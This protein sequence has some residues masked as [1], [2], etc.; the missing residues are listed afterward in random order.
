M[1]KV[2]VVIPSLHGDISHLALMC[3]SAVSAG[4][5]PVVIANSEDL[6]KKLA[7]TTIPNI[8]SR[9]NDGYAA[10]VVL[11]AQGDDWDWLVILN[12]DLEFDSDSMVASLSAESL[13]AFGLNMIVHLDDE[14]PRRIPTTRLGVM[15]RVSL[16]YNVGRKVFPRNWR[17]SS[18]N[19]YRSFSAVA[20]G[21]EAWDRVGGLDVRYSFTY[22]DADF[23]R[24][25]KAAG[26]AEAA[27][28]TGIVH[29]HSQTTSHFVTAVIPVATWSAFEYLNKWCGK[30]V[31]NR[32]LII[33]AL[34]VRAPV[35]ALVLPDP[36][37][38][39]IAVRESLRA[40]VVNKTPSLPKWE[41]V[42]QTNEV[43]DDSC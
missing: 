34:L 27:K 2:R 23:V 7:S 42:P 31:L 16:L 26:V 22:E 29:N 3:E 5:S 33:L 30:S 19:H 24:R 37:V 8:T 1:T 13:N 28:H 6:Y 35:A 36:R 12:D 15:L 11:G 21:R 14:I 38:Q 20:I 25:A 18:E 9:R 4:A 40:L 39:L 10:S 32:I 43:G 41:I 17:R